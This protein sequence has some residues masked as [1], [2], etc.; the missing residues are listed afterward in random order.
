[1]PACKP[2]VRELVFMLLK[3]LVAAA[4]RPILF[5]MPEPKYERGA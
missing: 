1:M 2:L 4:D 3:S 5:T